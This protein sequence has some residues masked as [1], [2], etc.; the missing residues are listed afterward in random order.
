MG[1]REGRG[2]TSI[3]VIGKDYYQPRG[4]KPGPIHC[5]RVLSRSFGDVWE[6]PMG[7][8]LLG[9]GAPVIPEK[10]EEPLR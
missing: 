3:C 9:R 10:G 5:P 6:P 4:L 1:C 2:L 8:G 7:E